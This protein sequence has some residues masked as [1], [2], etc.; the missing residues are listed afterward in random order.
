M[1][2][3]SNNIR[4]GKRLKQISTVSKGMFTSKFLLLG[5][6]QTLII[7][8]TT[9]IITIIRKALANLKVIL[10]SFVNLSNEQKKM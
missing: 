2:H 3:F 4:T 10:L 1:I 6:V 8:V 9:I 5:I 7:M